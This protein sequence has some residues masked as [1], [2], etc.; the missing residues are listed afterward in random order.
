MKNELE[1]SQPLKIL[2]C[3]DDPAFRKLVRTYLH[4]D[5]E[6]RYKLMEAGNMDEIR[7]ALKERPDIIFMDILMPDKSGMEWLQEIVQGKIA[8]VVML[9]GFGSEEIAVQSIREGAIDYIPKDH[10]TKDRLWGTIKVTLETWKRMQA[11]D[12]LSESEKRYQ[13]LFEHAKDG[14][15]IEDLTGQIIEVNP[16]ACEMLG[17]TS[18]ELTNLNVKDIVPPEIASRHSE[19][20]Q[21]IQKTGHI[22]TQVE[23]VRKDGTRIALEMSGTIVEVGGKPCVVVIARDVTE[24][25]QIEEERVRLLKE[26]EKKNTEMENFTYTVSHDLRAPLVTVQGFVGMLRQDLERHEMEKVESD[27]KRIEDAV[28]KMEL[29]LTDTLELSRIGRVANPPEEVPFAEI[30]QEALKQTASELKS[31]RVKVSVAEDFPAVHV[32]RVRIVEALVNLITNSINYM[33]EN[34]QPGIEIGYRVDEGKTVFFVR[35]N[36][37][38]IDPSQHEKVFRLFYKVD[39]RGKGTGAGLAIVKR[40]IEV[41]GGRI[42]IESEKGKGCTVCFTLPVV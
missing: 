11:E 20:V 42:W 18:D 1:A 27:L 35:D 36:G 30:A 24:R 22:F 17:Y 2:L 12:A 6:G 4:K 13:V 9:T 14:I 8:P 33:G 37:I 5:T 23:N 15:F 41:H 25:K 32:D 34:P 16:K 29:L 40:I 38:G 3:D 7:R 26:L 39:N 31:S 10:L 28:T 21:Q 19:F